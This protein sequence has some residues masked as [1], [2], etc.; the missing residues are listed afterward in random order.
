MLKGFPQK[1]L[2]NSETN[3]EIKNHL[4]QTFELTQVGL[5][6]THYIFRFRSAFCAF[7]F[8]FFFLKIADTQSSLLEKNLSKHKRKSIV[9][10]RC[11]AISSSKRSHLTMLGRPVERINNNLSFS[12][13]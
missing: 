3:F 5:S 4:T 7:Y 11:G 1:H 13:I 6:L 8:S 2:N 9:L 12:L 10:F